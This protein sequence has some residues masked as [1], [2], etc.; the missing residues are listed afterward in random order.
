VTRALTSTRLIASTRPTKSG[1]LDICFRSAVTVLTGT[2]AGAVTCAFAAI[3]STQSNTAA[4]TGS[5]IRAPAKS[6]GAQAG[7]LDRSR[8]ANDYYNFSR[9][10]SKPKDI[11]LFVWVS[12]LRV[13]RGRR[14]GK[15]LTRRV[16]T[17]KTVMRL[18]HHLCARQ[19]LICKWWARRTIGSALWKCRAPAL[20]TLQAVLALKRPATAAARNFRAAMPQCRGVPSSSRRASHRCGGSRS[21]I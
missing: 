13:R 21:C 9:T 19:T 6:V 3:P 15:A 5:R 4:L 18:A 16:C 14:V 11:A 12:A 8:S 1:V 7:C 17:L 2:G 10:A 20:P